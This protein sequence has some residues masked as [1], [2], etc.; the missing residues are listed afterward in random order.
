MDAVPGH[1]DALAAVSAPLGPPPLRHTLREW[2]R[3][4]WGL[5]QLSL[6]WR[7][8]LSAPPGDGR[9][10]LVL[11][12]LFN[13]DRSTALMVRY[14]NTIGYRASG[15]GLGRNLGRR[16]IGGEGERLLAIVAEAAEE[17]RAPV[18]LIGVSLGGIMARLAAHLL[19]DRVAEVITVSS[20]Y[21]GPARATR[22]WRAY[23]RITGDRI[24]AAET[25]ALAALIRSPLPVPATAI[26][27]RS[28]GLVNGLA[29]RGQDCRAIE[30]CSSHLGVQTRAEVLRAI[31]GVLA[32]RRAQ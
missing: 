18:T 7:G 5:A 26:W 25:L 15:W 10:V 1:R 24:D 8:L 9:R 2:P 29:C 23:Q 11:P 4:A 21:A 22:V 13:S 20:P 6:T 27:S 17:A 19:P 14:L 16:T 3:A 28:D 30:V 12:G 31:A 32:E